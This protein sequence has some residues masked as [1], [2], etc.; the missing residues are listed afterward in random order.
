MITPRE[1]LTNLLKKAQK[2]DWY[3]ID[4]WT[5]TFGFV[6][7]HPASVDWASTGVEAWSLYE[8]I[9]DTIDTMCFES[10]GTNIFTDYQTRI[11]EL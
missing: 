3:G 2:I 1:K 10:Y 9:V 6:Y 4:H 8:E 11:L 5:V 7:H